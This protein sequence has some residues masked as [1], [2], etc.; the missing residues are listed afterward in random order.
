MTY[1]AYQRADYNALSDDAFRS[2]IRRFL[3]ENHPPELRH[4]QAAAVD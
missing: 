3:T 1:E 2:L 4:P